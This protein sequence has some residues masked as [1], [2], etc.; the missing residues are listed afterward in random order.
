MEDSHTV[1]SPPLVTLP[2]LPLVQ[3]LCDFTRLIEFCDEDENGNE[4][5]K[6]TKFVK[7]DQHG[8]IAWIGSVDLPK[9]Q[10][11]LQQALSSLR[12]VPDSEIYPPVPP[13]IQAVDSSIYISSKHTW[14]KRPNISI[15]PIVETE[16]AG[17]TR[18]AD[19]FLEEIRVYQLIQKSPH[20]NLVEFQGCLQKENRIVGALLKRYSLT[21]HSRVLGYRFRDSPVNTTSYLK[22]IQDGLEHLHGLGLAHNDINPYNIMLDEGDRLVII[23]MGAAKPFGEP[24]AQMGTPGWNDG[25]EEISSKGNDD[26]GLQKIREW[27]EGGWKGHILY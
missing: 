22:A 26:I 8:H 20:P 12:R 13:D 9:K 18:V 15:Y 16:L 5:V 11:S 24:M 17:T 10:I 21:L 1:I 7:I 19:D 27:L 14:L 25:F 2:D 3:E 4:I 6:Y 23:D